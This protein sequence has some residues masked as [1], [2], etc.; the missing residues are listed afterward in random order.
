LRFLGTFSIWGW[1][2]VEKHLLKFYLLAPLVAFFASF[3]YDVVV[4]YSSQVGLP[5]ALL[6]RLFRR[7]QPRL[8]VF[9]VETFGRPAGGLKLALVRFALP[10]I[11]HVVYAS[12]GQRE[13]YEQTLPEILERSTHI[14]IGIGPYEK[15]QPFEAAATSDLIVAIGKHDR[16]FRD[17]AVL[18]KAFSEVSDR[19]RLLIVGRSDIPA[20][21]RNGVAIPPN[22][23][24]LPYMPIEQ[25][26]AQVEG[27]R[28]A[29]LPLP[30]RNQSLGQLSILFLMAM[31]KA[32][33]ATRVI[34][35]E[36]YLDENVTGLFY[37][38]G[39]ASELAQCMK[40]LLDDSE[41][42]VEMGRKARSDVL[43]KFSDKA[44]GRAWERCLMK[45]V[46][47]GATD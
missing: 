4:A 20:E 19:A 15:N 41:A 10:A 2:R 31:G 6:F 32:V 11:D 24:M 22:V 8:V 39:D 47:T 13:F 5:L 16:R 36:D 45:V 42:V 17:W 9:D 37:A 30:E 43:E 26:A 25:L 27:A 34:G 14:P 44:M 3:R 1:T 46:G 23:T 12:T 40:K 18:L 28:F 7:R 33:V 21:D 35:V 29:V 38:P